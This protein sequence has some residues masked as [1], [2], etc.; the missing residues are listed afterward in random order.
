MV[1]SSFFSDYDQKETALGQ[2]SRTKRKLTEKKFYQMFK[3]VFPS[4]YSLF[5]AIKSLS[6]DETINK[7]GERKQYA[8]NCLLAQRLESS[9]IYDVIADSLIHSY[10]L[11]EIVTV[12]D[13]FI[14]KETDAVCIKNIVLDEFCNLGLNPVVK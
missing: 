12:H 14:V 6:W 10:G 7:K 5:K 11:T 8:N 9:I 2:N 13:C 4:V 1:Y 3:E